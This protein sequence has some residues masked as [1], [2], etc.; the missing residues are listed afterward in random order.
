M[1][2]IDFKIE[3]P[4]GIYWPNQYT[5]IKIPCNP[6]KDINIKSLSLYD[7]LDNIINADFLSF[8]NNY[9]E[10]GLFVSLYPYEVKKMYIEKKDLVKAQRKSKCLS[11]KRTKSN[12]EISNGNLKFVIPKNGMYKKN[13]VPSPILSVSSDKLEG[14]GTFTGHIEKSEVKVS[15]KNSTLHAKVSIKYNFFEKGI[16]QIDILT[17]SKSSELIIH[18]INNTNNKLSLILSF[19][20]FFAKN[21]YA[22]MHTPLKE[23]GETD[24]WK[25]IIYASKLSNEPVLMQPFYTWDINTA[26]LIQYWDDCSLLCIVP[27]KPGRWENPSQNHILANTINGTGIESKG[28]KGSKEW[29]LSLTDAALKEEKITIDLSTKYQNWDYMLN[30]PIKNVY[31]A[32][33]LCAIYGGPNLTD[34]LNWMSKIPDNINLT[35]RLLADEDDIKDTRNRILSWPWMYKTLMNHKDDST[36]FDPAGVYMALKDEVYAKKAKQCISIW[37]E[38]RIQL[39]TCF[40]YSLHEVVCI[41]LSRPLRLIAIDYD[42]TCN[43]KQYSSQDKRFIYSAFAFLMKSMESRDY[44]PDRKNGFKM[45]NRNFHSDRFSALGVCACLLN[46]Y[47]DCPVVIRYVQRQA[48]LELEYCIKESGAWIEA[49]N[50]QAYSM[51]YLITLFAALKNSGY[52]DFFKNYKFRKTLDFLADIQTCY[53]IRYGAHMLPTIGDTAANYWSQ[54]FSNIFAWAGSITK[55]SAFSKRMIRAWNR[56]GNPVICPGGELNSTFKMLLLCNNSLPSVKDRNHSYSEYQGFGSV[57]KTKKS[58]LSIKSGD[59]SMHYDHDESSILWYE[60]NVPVLADIGSQYFPACDASFMHNRISINMNTDQARGDII[61]SCYGKNVSVIVTKT[62]ISNIQK[63]PWFPVTDSSWNFRYQ[64]VPYDIPKHKWKRSLIYLNNKAALVVIDE[65]TGNLPFEQNFL[66]MT[67]SYEKDNNKFSFKGQFDVNST[68]WIFNCTKSNIY[69]WGYLGL[70]EPSFKKAFASDWKK[71][72]WMWEKPIKPM[73]E[74]VQILRNFCNPN[75]KVITF[76]TAHKDKVTQ[77][78][79]LLSNLSTIQWTKNNET[80]TIDLDNVDK[81][82]AD[83]LYKEY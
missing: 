46:N 10:L 41:R 28:A 11:V 53:D 36:G 29:V 63:W 23:M 75:S 78:T 80:I 83:E 70:D 45:G 72:R 68:A 51:N 40:G 34:T 55:S 26:T 69:D 62:D 50:Y 67:S 33:R 17:Y 15:I 4:F 19:P 71:Y 6:D 1:N 64:S 30:N 32:D 82:H 16:Y 3:E 79:Q 14:V 57:I 37:L 77:N 7:S 22:R 54:A 74:N 42:L 8:Q 35:P 52:K 81:V 5:K 39:L 31:R 48:S 2:R 56:A 59:I 38:S 76:I 43:S 58:Y 65:V 9:I 49:P 60:Y 18:E 27:I 61:Y 47:E 20:S 12:I 66:F 44:W 24:E 21:T 25:R 13:D 73:A